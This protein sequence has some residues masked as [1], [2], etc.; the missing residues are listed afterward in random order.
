MS[1]KEKFEEVV[2]EMERHERMTAAEA[3]Y[4]RDSW[5]KLCERLR[6]SHKRELG[7]IADMRRQLERCGIYL[8]VVIRDSLIAEPEVEGLNTS[9]LADDVWEALHK[10]PPRNCDRFGSEEEA[11]IAFLNE[12][13]LISVEDL[14]YD[15]FEGWTE[16][17]KG[18]YAKWLM[19]PVV[20]EKK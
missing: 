5:H 8:G 4:D 10:K 16:Q 20:E 18:E 9:D 17:M 14:K 1:E 19:K 2:C 3:W 12:V 6:E 7:C 15:P 11:Q 13:W